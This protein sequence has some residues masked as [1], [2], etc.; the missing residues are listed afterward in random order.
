M[1]VC[2]LKS[3]VDDSNSKTINAFEYISNLSEG[4][5]YFE[6]FR[7][8]D[9][10]T[11]ETMRMIE[12]NEVNDKI[13]ISESAAELL[14]GTTDVVGKTVVYGTPRIIAGVFE[15]FKHRDY[16]QP[17]PVVVQFFPE[18]FSYDFQVLF[19]LK[20]GVDSRK[21]E[22]RFNEEIMPAL[23]S[24]NFYATGITSFDEKGRILAENFG[25][26]NKMRL[27]GTFTFFA[28]VCTFLGIVGTFWVRTNTRRPD[29]GIMRSIG[30]TRW[31]IM[32]HFC[33]E[34]VLLFTIAFIVGL[35]GLA[36][37]VKLNGLWSDMMGVSRFSDD[38]IPNAKY[39]QNDTVKTFA[40][41]SV[42]TY[43]FMVVTVLIG[44]FI[45]VY[46]AIDEFPADA[47]R[48]E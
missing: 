28:L 43:L 10:R 27:N 48:D 22:K 7:I 40:V 5:N 44:T 12:E 45:P 18:F 36:Y 32:R 6:T 3:D 21:F 34:S 38:F 35:L 42:V 15:D 11:G 9:V 39:W 30:A 17:Y 19:R 31:Q 25:E 33:N 29:I 20:E 4:S 2:M 46:R 47:L 24:G 8:K 23:K 26:Y 1:A 41:V 16:N 14:Y 37:Y 13:Y